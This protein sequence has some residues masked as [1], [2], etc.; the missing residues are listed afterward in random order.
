MQEGFPIENPYN[1]SAGNTYDF[2]PA[3][4]FEHAYTVYLTLYNKI[5]YRAETHFGAKQCKPNSRASDQ[6][7]HCLVS[8][9]SMQNR[10]KV[11]TFA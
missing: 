5:L 10:V 9:F 11:K 7:L 8:E 3:W 4:V 1:V 6:G 2:L